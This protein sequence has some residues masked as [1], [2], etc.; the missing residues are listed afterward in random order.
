MSHTNKKLFE[1]CPASIAVS[2]F[3]LETDDVCNLWRTCEFSRGQ[4]G[5]SGKGS[6]IFSHFSSSSDGLRN[7]LSGS[8]CS[9]GQ[10]AWKQR[11]DPAWAGLAPRQQPHPWRQ[12]VQ[13][14][15]V[16]QKDSVSLCRISDL[17]SDH[18]LLVLKTAC[19]CGMC[20]YL[21]LHLKR[22]LS[23]D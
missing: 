6:C 8:C 20:C 18:A 13:R 23:K 21:L 19:S 14:M 16:T 22:P 7:C 17:L 1:G 2:I 9:E 3:W 15:Y 10:I 11:S 4:L 5:T 12:S